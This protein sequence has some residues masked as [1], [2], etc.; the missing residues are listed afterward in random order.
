MSYPLESSAP[1]QSS[2][3]VSSSSSSNCTSCPCGFSSTDSAPIAYTNTGPTNSSVA[4]TATSLFVMVP[5]S[6][7]ASVSSVSSP[8]S[9]SLSSSS[10]TC[11]NDAAADGGGSVLAYSSRPVRYATGEI[12][13]VT[14]EM[15]VRGHGQDWGHTEAS[16]IAS[17]ALAQEPT[18]TV[19]ASRR[20]RNWA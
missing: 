10:S 2:S 12:R 7:S 13:M 19:G 11:S 16:V 6:P 8:S 18:A 3:S 17:A 14:R 9:S 1:S 20:F 5:S 15:A 4:T